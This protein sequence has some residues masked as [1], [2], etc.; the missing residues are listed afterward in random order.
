[1]KLDVTFSFLFVGGKQQALFE[2]VL[3]YSPG[4][5]S[6]YGSFSYYEINY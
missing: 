6:H 1:V 4:A 3:I 5:I 2:A